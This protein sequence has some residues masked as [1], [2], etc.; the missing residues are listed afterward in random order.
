M[1]TINKL[2]FSG[3]FL[4]IMLVLSFINPN[5]ANAQY[6]TGLCLQNSYQTCIGNN[7]YWYDS[8]GNQQGI[9]Q[10]CQNGCYGNVCNN[11]NNYYDYNNYNNN[12]TYHAYKLCS[13]NNIYW[14]SSCGAQQDFYASCTG[15]QICQ[16]GQCTFSI[17]DPVL[18]P[19]NNYIAYYRTACYNNSIS[20]YDSLGV[21]SGL[22][23]NCNDNNI[24][25]IDTCSDKSCL[26]T[27][28]CDGTTCISG[29]PDFTKYCSNTPIENNNCGNGLCEPA[30]GET[31]TTCSVDCKL[32]SDVNVLSVSFFS[33]QDPASSQ[34]QKTAQIGS[35]G[36]IYFMITVANSSNSQIDNVNVSANIPTE[37]SSLGNLQLNGVAIS[38]D[39][40]AGINIGSIA[41]NSTKPVTFEG[42]TQ[43]ITSPETKSATA[44]V[45]ISSSN[46]R[47]Q[48]DSVSI[49]FTPSQ[50][51]AAAVTAP[52][53]SGFWA[54]LKQWYLWIIVALILV[55]LFVVVFKRFSSDV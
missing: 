45:N 38:G 20:W 5:V 24:C 12:C 30:L 35:N 27:L 31:N 7:L 32:N 41:P 47:A 4:S 10:Y 49:N 26:N 23:K 50:V 29:S 44:S 46:E 8:C 22:Y 52:E 33:K 15:N 51:V 48:S 17:I 11:N 21:V 53:S 34:W 13:G 42:K 37:I 54:F 1:Q 39:I 14:Y 25:T 18:P 43:I 28:K 3:I 2:I 6:Y 36:Q 19:I 9:A 55:F 40:V 16:Y